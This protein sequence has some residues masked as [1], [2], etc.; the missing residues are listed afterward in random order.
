MSLLVFDSGIGGLGVVAELRRLEPGLAI[1]YLADNAGFPYGDKPD[2]QLTRRIV[3]LI[4]TAI[5]RLDPQAI[6][7][8]CN[9]AS[10]VALDAL[11]RQFPRPF[12][13]CVPPIKPAAAASRSRV[14][15]VLATAA[16]VQRPYLER[17]IQSY[18]AGCTVHRYGTP[19]LAA[20]AEA[21]FRGVPADLHILKAA[22]APLFAAD[23][24]KH[25][26]AMALGCTHYTFLLQELLTLYPHIQWFDPAGPVA[27]QTL[28]V[29]KTLPPFPPQQDVALTT[30]PL[31][32]Y[33][34][35]AARYANYGFK[36][37]RLL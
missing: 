37:L 29:I 7:I 4:G 1:D 27:R 32:D 25:I 30:A 14:I 24:H 21:K 17:L 19:V 3:T 35:M 2:G 13:G 26:D 34:I 11:R 18:A 16:T 12:I 5:E 28:A 33:T 31:P 20:M 23:A 9:T 36:A 22:I 6:V 15:G 10:T 8:A